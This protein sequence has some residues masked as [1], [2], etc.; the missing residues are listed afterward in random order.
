MATII[1]LFIVLTL[2]AIFSMQNATPVAI[3]FLFWRF[4]AS[5]AIVIFL[6]VISGMIAGAIIISL[7]RLKPS[8]KNITKNPY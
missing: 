1:I 2:V 5:L 8:S 3:T 6:S 7:L 4:E